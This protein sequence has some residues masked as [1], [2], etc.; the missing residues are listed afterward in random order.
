[1]KK[2][3][4]ISLSIRNAGEQYYKFWFLIFNE[5]H[6]DEVREIMDSEPY[7]KWTKE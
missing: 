6:P 1:M 5:R 4:D 7:T 2:T 3:E